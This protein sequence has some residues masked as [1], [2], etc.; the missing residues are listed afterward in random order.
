[1]TAQAQ[2]CRRVAVHQ[3]NF[4][5]W[6]GFFD[7]L[8]RAD[9]FISLDHV[10]F[11]GGLGNWANRSRLIVA[12]EPRWSTAPIVRGSLQ[13]T[14]VET[15]FDE[16]SRWR[17]KLIGT[18]EASYRKAPFFEEAMGLFAPLILHPE[19]RL[20]EYNLNAIGEIASALGLDPGKIVRS[21]EMKARSASTQ[22]LIDLVKETDGEI[23]IYGGG[24]SGYQEDVSFAAAGVA[25]EAQRF[26]HPVYRQI[27]AG[28][29]FHPG[30]SI[31]D[32]VMNLGI[33]DTGKMVR[34][35]A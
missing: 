21:S 13:Q 16:R 27:N 14:I 26:E 5:P 35:G 19:S 12:G 33:H 31:I 18:L 10:Q 9:V 11:P 29:S 30:L 3:P 6:L 23:Y 22:L 34:S 2:R 25:L 20:A 8:A 17:R 1:M 7:K 4:F 32:A 15:L 24:A 28:E